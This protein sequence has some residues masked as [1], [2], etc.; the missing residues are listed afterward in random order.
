M[1]I[2][3]QKIVIHG[4]V[5]GVYFRASAKDT[6]E[7]LDLKG[8][9]KNE[10]GG[11]VLAEVEGEAEAVAAFIQWCRQGPPSAH[12]TSVQTLEG[13]LEHYPDFQVRR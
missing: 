7:K 2:I 11:D 9:V 6:A 10:P 3:H 1:A 8:Y 13:A 4:Q 5:Q 12:V